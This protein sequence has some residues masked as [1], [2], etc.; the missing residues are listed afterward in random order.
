MIE[1]GRVV[2]K[3][4]GRDA[5]KRAI[6][7]DILDDKFVLLDGETRRRK[8]N[9][10]HI[11]PL[12]EVV[13]IKKNATREEVKKVFKDLGIELVD[14]KP[15]EKKERPK[16]VRKKKVIKEEGKDVKKK[17]ATKEKKKEV[18][19]ENNNKKVN[20]AEKKTEEKK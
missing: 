16:K 12:K 8:C 5:G 20:P 19:K 17:G 4:A 9:V 2:M 15:K 14:T 6:I 7:I 3:T 10:L 1:V 13:E 11:E 18:K